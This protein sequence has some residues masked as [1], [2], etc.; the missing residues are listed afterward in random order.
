MFSKVTTYL[1]TIVSPK[2]RWTFRFRRDT[3]TF[4]PKFFDRTRVGTSTNLHQV[5]ERLGAV[6][7]WVL[8]QDLHR[9]P[10]SSY[11]ALLVL[12]TVLSS[13]VRVTCPGSH[14]SSGPG[15]KVVGRL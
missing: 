3:F 15:S 10:E 14:V 8:F 13:P 12:T 4:E 5:L 6:L 7:R 11:S 2:T 9:Y 1:G